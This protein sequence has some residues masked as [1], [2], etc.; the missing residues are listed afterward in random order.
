[1]RQISFQGIENIIPRL[2]LFLGLSRTPHGL[3]DVATPAMVAMLQLGHFPQLSTI[4]IGLIAAFSGYTAVYAMNDLIDVSVDRERLA[5]KNVPR[6]F[7]DIDTVMVEHPVAKGLL[8]FRKGIFWVIFWTAVA[9]VTITVLNPVCLLIF[10]VSACCEALYCKLLKITHWK[11]VSSA[12]VKASGGLAGVYAVNPQPDPAFVVFSFLWLACWEIGGQNIA[13]DIVDMEED[14]KVGAKT[15]VTVRSLSKSVY[16]LLVAASMA[17]FAGVTIFLLAGPGVGWIYPVGATVLGYLL[18]L[19]PA[20]LVYESPSP[21]T[22]AVLF[23]RT[24]FMPIAFLA[25]TVISIWIR[26]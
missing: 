22:A 4:I 26:I 14:L 5:L 25:L 2:K 19:G 18:I 9:M 23:N 11:I 7:S 15:I 1:M 8:S 24:S 16:V 12:I 17:T 13:N 3:L 21:K 20:K 6:S 10:L